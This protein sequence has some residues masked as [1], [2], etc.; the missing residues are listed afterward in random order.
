MQSCA[1]IFLFEKEKTSG[2]GLRCRKRVE[3]E[4]DPR[5]VMNETNKVGFFVCRVFF[6][7]FISHTSSRFTRW[8][9]RRR[10]ENQTGRYV[11]V[12]REPPDSLKRSNLVFPSS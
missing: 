5:T 1:A 7:S 4:K 8:K 10:E 3:S 11:V 6:S 12:D 2:R 9:W